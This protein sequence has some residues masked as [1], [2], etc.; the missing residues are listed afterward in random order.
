[1]TKTI[2]E[3][4]AEALSIFDNA[5]RADAITR[6]GVEQ[7][8]FTLNIEDFR[9]RFIQPV[10]RQTADILIDKRKKKIRKTR[11]R[12]IRLSNRGR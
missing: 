12:N 3:I 4:T 10:M 9:E 2:S 11:L 1:M 6:K 7:L 5:T 8:G